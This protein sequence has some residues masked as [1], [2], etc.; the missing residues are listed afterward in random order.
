MAKRNDTSKSGPTRNPTPPKIRSASRPAKPADKPASIPNLDALEDTI[1]EERARLMEAH[2][3]LNCVAIAMDAE[4][5]SPE[6]G[7]HYPTLIE[8]ASDLINESIRRLDTAN[9][10]RAMKTRDDEEDEGELE[11]EPTV[12]RGG[13]NEVREPSMTYGCEQS[14][15]GSQ[16]AAAGRMPVVP[17][18]EAQGE[19][20]PDRTRF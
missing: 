6:G 4:D 12:K 19:P 7:P 16:A 2:S 3:I 14:T 5:V 1:E 10:G 11:E 17:E 15:A 8:T 20:A 18:P 13:R 9:L